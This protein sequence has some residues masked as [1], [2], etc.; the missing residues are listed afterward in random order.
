[1]GDRE[2]AQASRSGQRQP[3]SRPKR[4]A[5]VAAAF[6][7]VLVV[8]EVASHIGLLIL[9]RRAFSSETMKKRRDDVLG[10]TEESQ[11]QAA[12]A[13]Q[14]AIAH[15]YLGYVTDPT[16]PPGAERP[17][18]ATVS[19]YG[20]NG[21]PPIQKKGGSRVVVGIFGGSV[22]MW[23]WH[24]RDAL[25]EALKLSPRYRDRDIVFVCAAMGGY[26]QPQLLMA[27]SYFLSL[28]GEFDL[29]INL[30]GFN[31]VAL[32]P[33]ENMTDG[34]FP[35]FPR[36][37]GTQAAWTLDQDRRRLLGLA[38]VAKDRREDWAVTMSAP[39]LRY[40]AL[41]NLIWRYRD[42]SIAA[43]IA[44]I[45]TQFR[46]RTAAAK[47]GYMVTGPRV[48]FANDDELYGHLTAVW[49]DSSLSMDALCRANKAG[50]FH[51]LQPNQY[52]AGSKPIGPEEA[53]VAVTSSQYRPGV[54]LGYPWLARRAQE[55]RDRGVHFTDLTQIFADV[56]EPIYV[57]DC[58]H[59]NETGM[60]MLAQA[61][62]SA[63]LASP[64][65]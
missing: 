41:A 47:K 58:C 19:E 34:V 11:Q 4:A 15:P 56:S 32:P 59:M 9:D 21:P 44:R 24:Y 31:E 50:Y 7:I 45:Q 40:S 27:L 42:A 17:S 51:F 52:V 26:K 23:L 53:R 18:G 54:E 25:E 6:L 55:L 12:T 22:A 20:F 62:A 28:G 48:T 49:R 65:P 29:V 64:P 16:A 13:M 38:Q 10:K 39:L 2:P 1:M 37:W 46:K 5:F 8:A 3:L 36:N 63:V 30:D 60:R 57:D 61:I 14:Y 43:E 33:S 35:A